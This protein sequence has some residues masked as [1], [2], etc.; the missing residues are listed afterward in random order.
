MP[1]VITCSFDECEKKRVA[2]GLCHGHY[3]QERSGKP[4]APLRSRLLKGED[5]TAYFW[6]RV[7]KPAGDAGCW[8][9]DGSKNRNGYV[10]IGKPIQPLTTRLSHRTAHFLATG[11]PAEAAQIDHLCFN[12]ACC[13]PA[14]LRIASQS[15]NNQNREIGMS[16]KDSGTGVR[17]VSLVTD[18][19]LD[20]PYVV[21]LVV[22]GKIKHM[23][24]YRTIKE[25]DEAAR[26]ARR[27][28]YPASQ[29]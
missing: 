4:L 17:N 27:D 1:K 23:G 28:H 21:R 9:Y 13:N 15:E 8:F 22:D 7:N 16:R 11:D 10:K 14:H 3:S 25:A 24:Y 29:W 20:K 12:V 5:P 18:R 2:R 26:V 19:K 6:A